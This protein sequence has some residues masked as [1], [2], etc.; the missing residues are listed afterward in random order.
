[1]N[2]TSNFS[3][4]R[5]GSEIA[6]ILT[7]NQLQKSAVWELCSQQI[8]PTASSV[9]TLRIAT[10]TQRTQPTNTQRRFNDTMRNSADAILDPWRMCFA[11]ISIF[12]NW[13]FFVPGLVSSRTSRVCT[14][15]LDEYLPFSKS[16]LVQ[17]EKTF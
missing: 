2:F 17:V 6:K 1:M 5:V 12:L 16:I 9:S 11:E 10:T 14:F 4:M 15:F 7:G 8:L 3:F 13:T